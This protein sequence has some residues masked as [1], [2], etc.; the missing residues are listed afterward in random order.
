MEKKHLIIPALLTAL[1]GASAPGFAQSHYDGDRDGYGQRDRSD[2]GDRGNRDYRSD[3]NDR[4]D[5]GDR[6]EDR[7]DGYQARG[8]GRYGNEGW[9]GDERRWSGAGPEHSFRRGDRLPERYRNHQYVVNNYREHHLRPP[10]RGYHWV[11]T[12]GDY[13]LAAIASGVI[14][15]LIINH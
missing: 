13:V 11:Q 3:R 12:G 8:G 6:R 7:R 1:L 4:N 9:G 2:R 14:A 15:D 10:P 5:R